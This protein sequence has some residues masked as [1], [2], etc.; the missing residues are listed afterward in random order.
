MCVSDDYNGGCGC[1]NN[2]FAAS[3]GVQPPLSRILR[4]LPDP[5]RRY[6]IYHLQ[7]EDPSNLDKA[8]RFVAA[9]DQGVNPE[10]ISSK[11][12]DRLKAELY[13]THLPKLADL[14]IIDNDDRSGAIRFR[15]PPG[16]LDD[17]L[18]LARLE[19]DID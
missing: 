11:T 5:H 1:D 19:D 10:D 9:C 16:G 17:F 18:D 3:G 4:S 8:A 13:H 7:E 12:H 14:N 6:L 2:S 15:D